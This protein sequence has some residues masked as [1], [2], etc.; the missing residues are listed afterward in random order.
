MLPFELGLKPRVAGCGASGVCKVGA[1]ECG[2]SLDLTSAPGC[3][4]RG[5]RQADGDG[6]SSL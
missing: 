2:G 6:R 5:S 1:E 3:A 4:G